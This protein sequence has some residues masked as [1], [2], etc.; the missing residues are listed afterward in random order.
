M[1][2]IERSH[3]MQ[4]REIQ[5][6]Q[7]SHGPSRQDL[8][9]GH[10]AKMA[11]RRRASIGEA[12]LEVYSEDLISYDLRDIER[13]CLRLAGTERAD[14]E[15][16][17]PE[18]GKLERMIRQAQDVRCPPKAAHLIEMERYDA[19]RA[20]HPEDFVEL[21][22]DE[23]FQ[24][25]VARLNGRIMNPVTSEGSGEA[26]QLRRREGYEL[27]FYGKVLTQ[28]QRDGKKRLEAELRA[29]GNK[30]VNATGRE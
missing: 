9:K 2:G 26:Q 6:S 3:A 24:A 18:F 29:E 5:H 25:G 14:G 21:A 30:Q 15:E 11:I 23:E 1:Q 7:P 27:R 28:E 10:L 19:E 20:A 16:A 12:E 13:A 22:K 17:F 4:A 8:I